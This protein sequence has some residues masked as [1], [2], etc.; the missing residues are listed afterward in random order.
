MALDL[1]KQAK[2]KGYRTGTLIDY[3]GQFEGTDTL[4]CGEFFI[5]DGDLI[6]YE[7]EVKDDVS[8]WR[9]YDTIYSSLKGWV[10]IVKSKHGFHL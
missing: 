8:D 1:I 6:K 3:E 4:G 10:K 7:N 5:K 9:R 2:Q